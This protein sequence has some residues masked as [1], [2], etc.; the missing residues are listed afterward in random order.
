MYPDSPG[1][2]DSVDRRRLPRGS[3]SDDPFLTVA[4]SRLSVCVLNNESVGN[5]WGIELIVVRV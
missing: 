3:T 1:S 2:P 4:A 5:R